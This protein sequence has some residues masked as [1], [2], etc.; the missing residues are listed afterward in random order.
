[1][2]SQDAKLLAVYD[3]LEREIKAL[4]L[5][6]GKD[7]RDGND[8][9]SIKGDRGADGVSIKG[10]TGK[11][12]VSVKGDRG[13]SGV[14][15][16]G[17]SVVSAEVDFDNH[18]VLKMSDGTVIDAGDVGTGSGGGDKYYRSGSKVTVNASSGT[19]TGKVTLD[20][21]TGAKTSEVVVTGV[22][23]VTLDSIV[24]LTLRV[25]AT[26]EHTTDDL[27]VDPIRLLVKDYI[28]GT[29]FTI[30]GEMDNAEAN[31]TYNINWMLG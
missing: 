19:V 25:E 9:K 17:V 15:T 10:D 2:I 27:L 29:G 16:D 31:G 24:I 7:G 26:V 3:K 18:L 22:A 30:Y 8:G 23:D 21:G 13:A 12:G 14:G 5:K 28:A 20:F 1:M 4:Q 6:H 11:D